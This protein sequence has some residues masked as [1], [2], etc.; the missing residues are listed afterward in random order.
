MLKSF[1]KDS[2]IY[3]I[4]SVLSR[5]ISLLLIPFYTRVLDPADY[6]A[7]DLLLVFLGLIN[8]TVALEVS[9]G[10]ARFYSSVTDQVSKGLYASTSFWFAFFC[11]LFFLILM[12]LFSDHISY[13]IFGSKEYETFFII[14]IFYIFLNGIFYMIQNQLRWELRSVSYGVVSILYSVLSA[15]AAVTLVVAGDMKV[16]GV[17]WGMLFGALISCVY[18]LWTLRNSYRFQFDIVKLRE[19]LLFSL[20]LVPSGLAVFSM[21]YIDRLMINH[22]LSLGDV[23]IYGMGYRMASVVGL[24]MVGFQMSLTPLVYANFEKPE[25]PHHLA[26]IFRIFLALALLFFS[27]ISIFVSEILGFL[28]APAYHSASV[29]IVF[30]VPALLL[31]NMYVFFPGISIAKKNHLKIFIYCAGLVVGIFFNVLLIPFVGVVG[32][33]ISTLISYGV[34]FTAYVVLSQKFYPVPHEGVKLTTAVLLVGLIVTALSWFDPNVLVKTIFMAL[35]LIVLFA[36]NLFRFSEIQQLYSYVLRRGGG[37][38]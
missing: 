15:S 31:F 26:I 19:M 18:G 9:Q 21:Q 14:G 27:F 3:T 28:V 25:V 17:L 8:L 12:Y 29:I 35:V 36:T 22:Y 23:G 20:P 24:L 6:G 16:E 11:Y 5:G 4:P 30:L 34:V 37:D 13:W 2:V 7:L 32:A 38:C 1:F 10:L 33:G